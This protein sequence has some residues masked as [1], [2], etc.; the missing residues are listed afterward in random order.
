LIFVVLAAFLFA[1]S[2]AAEAQQQK[3][4]PAPKPRPAA[5]PGAEA[6][7]A[8]NAE[9]LPAPLSSVNSEGPGTPVAPAVSPAARAEPVKPEAASP[10]ELALGYPMGVGDV[11]RVTVFQQPDMTTETRV[12]EAGTITV[13]LLGPVPVA[14]ATAKR[15][16]DRIAALLKARGF[17][18]DPQVIVTVLQFK[19]RQVSVLGLVAR[20][21][22]YSLEEGIYRLSDVLAIAGGALPDGADEVTLVR[23][24]DGRSQKHT[25]DLPS[26]FRSGDFSS[27]PEV[28]AGDSIYVAR[29]PLFYIYGEVNRP[30]AFRIEKGMTVMQALSM[31]GGISQRG[32]ERNLELRRR[33]VNGQYV[34]YRGSLTDPV[35]P[36]D[37]IFVRESLF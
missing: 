4:R 27:N 16:E 15:V 26:L 18:R 2:S 36:N 31:G 33:D 1:G 23:V 37:V 24:V 17:V 8:P 34:T 21:G 11:V 19:S 13:P 10:Q 28:I 9:P 3:P 7:I 20:P 30:G 32:S 25:V 29:A 14:G 22:R 35:L 12:S 6:P 5:A